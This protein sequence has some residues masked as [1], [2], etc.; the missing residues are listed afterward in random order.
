[1]YLTWIIISPFPRKLCELDSRCTEKLTG[2]LVSHWKCDLSR[3]LIVKQ[4]EPQA[5]SRTAVLSIG[6]SKL[7]L[8]IISPKHDISLITFIKPGNALTWNRCIMHSSTC[9]AFPSWNIEAG[10]LIGKC[11]IGEAASSHRSAI[12]LSLSLSLSL[13]RLLP[14]SPPPSLPPL[15]SVFC[16]YKYI[17]H[18]MP[19]IFLPPHTSI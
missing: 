17:H 3:S 2:R 19:T 6:K 18:A 4:F 12:G 13:H 10:D 7:R 8:I 5:R 9:P 1:M 14:T 15:A 11:S 16:R